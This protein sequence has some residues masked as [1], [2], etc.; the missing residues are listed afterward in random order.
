MTRQL[1]MQMLDALEK[2]DWNSDNDFHK[3]TYKRAITAAL[4]YLAE[5]E[6]AP[7]RRKPMGLDRHSRMWH[8]AAKLFARSSMVPF[9][10]YSMGIAHAEAAHGITGNQCAAEQA[11]QPTT[12]E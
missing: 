10:W 12:P 1:I 9:E 11:P 8:D 6:Q 5:P 3:K 7:A 2:A 4:A